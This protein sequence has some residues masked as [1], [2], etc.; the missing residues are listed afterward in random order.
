MIEITCRDRTDCQKVRSLV[1][2]CE[3]CFEGFD[4][5]AKFCPAARSAAP[6]SERSPLPTLPVVVGP[7]QIV[8]G[9][10]KLDCVNGGIC[11]LTKDESDCDDSEVRLLPLLAPCAFL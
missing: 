4:G 7:K 1:D 11:V 2:K 10:C 5:E 3:L 9:E 8:E 6:C